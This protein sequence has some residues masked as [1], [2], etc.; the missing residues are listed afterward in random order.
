[1]NFGIAKMFGATDKKFQDRYNYLIEILSKYTSDIL[2]TI[3]PIGSV[4]ISVSSTS[5]SELFGGTWVATG[6]GRVLVGIDSSQTEFDTLGETGGEKTHI[7]DVTEIPSHS[8]TLP[9]RQTGTNA[10]YEPYPP[11][12]AAGTTS[13]ISTSSTGGGLAH[14]N[15]QP[16]EVVYMWKRTA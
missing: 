10:Y 5:P 4:Y 6:V 1:M 9:M 16:Y 13:D 8:H 2:N 14:N 3:Y 11:F 7:L 12:T 15:L